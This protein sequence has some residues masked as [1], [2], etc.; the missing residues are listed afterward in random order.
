MH[1]VLYNAL[2]FTSVIFWNIAEDQSAQTDFTILPGTNGEMAAVSEIEKLLENDDQ[3]LGIS[4]R[5]PLPGACLSTRP[6]SKN[7]SCTLFIQETNKEKELGIGRNWQH[8]ALLKDECH[9]TSTLVTRFNFRP[10]NK[11]VFRLNNADDMIDLIVPMLDSLSEI[12]PL[13]KEELKEVFTYILKNG[14]LTFGLVDTITDTE[15]KYI[16]MGNMLLVEKEYMMDSLAEGAYRT[17]RAHPNSTYQSYA[18]PLRDFLKRVDMSDFWLQLVGNFKNRLDIYTLESDETALEIKRRAD[19]IYQALGVGSPLSVVMGTYTAMQTLSM[20]RTFLDQMFLSTIIILVGLG[21]LL[22]YTLMLSDVEEKTY[23]FGMIRAIGMNTKQLVLLLVTQSQLYAIPGTILGIGFSAIL[24]VIAVKVVGGIVFYDMPMFYE[25]V[26]AILTVVLGLLMPLAANFFPIQRAVTSTLRDSL[27]LYHQLNSDTRVTFTNLHK[28]GVSLEAIFMACL[29]IALGFMLFYGIPTAFYT[30]DI[31]TVLF[32]FIWVLLAML[33]GTILVSIFFEPFMERLLVYAFVCCTDMRFRGLVKKALSSHR[34]R[35]RK[36]AIM[37]T[38]SLAFVI[39][40]GSEFA[41]QSKQIVDQ[42][43]V[44]MGADL[45]FTAPKVTEAHEKDKLLDAMRKIKDIPNNNV[46][47]YTYMTYPLTAQRTIV[48]TQMGN[49]NNLDSASVNVVSVDSDF[50]SG[51]YDDFYVIDELHKNVA[52]WPITNGK[53]DVWKSLE[54]DQRHLTLNVENEIPFAGTINVLSGPKREVVRSTADKLKKKN[55]FP[56]KVQNTSEQIYHNYI[57]AVV[58]S[59]LMSS[60]NA[61]MNTPLRL[62]VYLRHNN[63]AAITSLNYLVKARAVMTKSSGM[64][65]GSFS[66]SASGSSMVI[67]SSQYRELLHDALIS[68]EQVKAEE[69]DKFATPL[70]SAFVLLNGDTPSDIRTAITD[71]VFVGIDGDSSS[72]DVPDLIKTVQDTVVVL[73]VFY[74]VFG[75]IAIIL[76]FFVLWISFTA[77]VRE[78]GWEFGVLR[79]IGLTGWQTVRIYIYEALILVTSCIIFGTIIGI[80]LA[81]ILTVQMTMFSEMPFEYHFPVELFVITVVLSV[82]VA[83]LGSILAASDMKNR[84]I[85]SVIRSGK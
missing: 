10:G 5:I 36:T 32:L 31:A 37:F 22:I 7:E 65:F 76:C 54:T 75:V 72:T 49:L 47:G 41:L 55:E 64:T 35:N 52:S 16:S 29:I 40:V 84:D 81:I 2:K 80:A 23:E 24:L 11:I 17:M 71:T 73:D 13:S 57:D 77:N 33:F 45:I 85:A 44:G 68:S 25:T 28:M 26:A 43:R 39:F 61:D 66:L 15:G 74:I 58:S 82:V 60:I 67:P 6:D 51:T 34:N 3:V 12:L 83:V 63:S 20:M 46:K 21:A 53:Q 30:G 69:F 1:R 4:S 78:N 79:S 48:M 50:L 56:K 14:S 27:D 59:G 42:V 70:Q 62:T 18:S 8:R 19:K 38:A 9:A